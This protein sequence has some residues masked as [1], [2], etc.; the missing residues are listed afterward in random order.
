MTGKGWMD[1]ERMGEK[2]VKWLEECRRQSVVVVVVVVVVVE[3]VMSR[4]G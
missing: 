2:E 1:D 3:L 4:T